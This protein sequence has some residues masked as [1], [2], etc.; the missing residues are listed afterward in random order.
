VP[1][2]VRVQIPPSP[3]LR[4]V[5]PEH[6]FFPQQDE[7]Q[8]ACLPNVYS[9]RIGPLNV[10]TENLEDRQ[11]Q[12]TVEVP[13]ERLKDAMRSTARRLS[14][15]TRIP[16][17]RPG[18]AP[19]NIVI[20]KFGEDFV[21]KETLDSLG[22]EIYRQ[23]LE[24]TELEPYGPGSFDE[25]V[26][27]D[28]LVL[29][30]TV[31]MPPEVALGDYNEIRIPYEEPV[32]DDEDVEATMEDIRQRHALIEPA[33]RPAQ[34]TDVV[35]ID[36]RGELRE[37]PEDKNPLLLENKGV[38][39]LVAEDT[40]WPI[41][42]VHEHLV[43][44]KAGD[45]CDFEHTFPDDYPNE[46]LQSLTA[47]FHL[48]CL[49]VKS[50]FVPEWSDDLAQN[51]GDYADLLDLRI[52]VRQGLLERAQHNYEN[53]YAQSVIETVVDG[54]TIKHPPM[55]LEEEITEMLIELE[56][57]MAMQNLSLEDYLKIEQKTAEDLRA[58]LEPQAKDR[59]MRALVLG[60]LVEVEE[61]DVKEDEVEAEIDRIV[62]PFEGQSEE[63]RKSFDTQSSR[64]RLTLDLLTDKAI[65][66]LTAIAR[67]E[68]ETSEEK[69]LDEEI[70]E[71]E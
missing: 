60:K 69:N 3:F 64:R 23:A 42:G 19:Y 21:L 67:G 56:R 4:L 5:I 17:F 65:K 49:E 26:S 41:P 7:P 55:L 58:E 27:Q 13:G 63:F 36:I 39:V 40:D 54:A 71:K 32:V 38:E 10:Q 70:K 57:R 53:E 20:N 15:E 34:L 18:K 14:R 1:Q 62:A 51:V 8:H 25:I 16:G 6:D 37:P 31:P 43:D 28:P 45:E 30:Y 50:R 33:D 66:H 22:Q 47:D 12:L 24:Q 35:V 2:G 68:A 44:L 11:V 59:L 46:N 52:K 9:W 29:R 61:L 48:T